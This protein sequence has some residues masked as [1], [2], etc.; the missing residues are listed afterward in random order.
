MWGE[1]TRETGGL[2]GARL[3]SKNQ[4]PRRGAVLQGLIRDWS[5]RPEAGVRLSGVE[6]G[7]RGWVVGPRPRCYH[8]QLFSPAGH[9]PK[10][11]LCALGCS[12]ASAT[13]GGPTG[14][15]VLQAT[16]VPRTPPFQLS[17]NFLPCPDR[18][19][20]KTGRLPLQGVGRGGGGQGPCWD[21]SQTQLRWSPQRPRGQCI[22]VCLGPSLRPGGP[23]GVGEGPRGAQ[24][25]PC[26]SPWQPL[27]PWT[28]STGK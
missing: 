10:P 27:S 20:P 5:G 24:N 12:R 2:G 8:N 9:G 16:A 23:G 3:C 21:S 6:D 25:A 13:Q 17:G 14:G 4:A 26:P 18:M 1:Y 11:P 19:T 22:L 15:P 7:D 28:M